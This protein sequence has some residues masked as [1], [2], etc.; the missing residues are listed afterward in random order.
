MRRRRARDGDVVPRAHG[1]AV[2]GEILPHRAGTRARPAVGPGPD[3]VRRRKLVQVMAEVARRR[4]IWRPPILIPAV[5][6]DEVQRP[7][8]RRQRFPVVRIQFQRREAKVVGDV[9]AASQPGTDDHA[10]H[11]G[12]V[13]DGARRDVR[14]RDAVLF[15]HR[16]DCGKQRLKPAPAARRLDEAAVFHL[17]PRLHSVGA[18]VRGI[19]PAFGQE[20][21]R[22]RSVREEC[23]PVP[24]TDLRHGA[25]GTR[26]EKGERDLVRDDVDPAVEHHV[27]VDGVEVRESEVSD[28]PLVPQLLK[29]K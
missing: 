24:E 29:G 26:V 13:E 25:G 10:R 11:R 28:Q 4:Q 9:L 15:R 22:Q 6:L 19:Q 27:E 14:H 8:R 17:R 21:A 1:A 12:P 23:D 3:G 20:S 16:P 2:A 5:S 7:A 18:R